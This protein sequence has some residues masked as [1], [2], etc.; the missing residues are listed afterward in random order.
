VPAFGHDVA[1]AKTVVKTGK[2]IGLPP[3]DLKGL[4]DSLK[5]SL[6]QGY[7]HAGAWGRSEVEWPRRRQWSRAAG[8]MADLG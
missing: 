3:A 6:A 4:A 7:R 2:Q 8:K 5:N 1:I